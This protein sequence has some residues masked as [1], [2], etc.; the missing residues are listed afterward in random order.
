LEAPLGT[1][2]AISYAFDDQPHDYLPDYVGT[3][4]GGGLLIAEAGRVAEKI[5]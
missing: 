1:P 2:Y 4:I 5:R 3:L